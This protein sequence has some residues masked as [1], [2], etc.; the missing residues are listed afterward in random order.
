M[1]YKQVYSFL[2]KR[3]DLYPSQYG[4]RSKH[5]LEFETDSGPEFH[6]KLM[7]GNMVDG[8]VHFFAIGE[9]GP[10]HANYTN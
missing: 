5:S 8:T 9:E 2:E 3:K 4:F 7:N 6:A 1:I 10:F